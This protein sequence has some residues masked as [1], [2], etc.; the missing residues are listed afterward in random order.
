MRGRQRIEAALSKDGSPEIPAVLCYEGIYV[1]DHWSQL[2]DVPWWHRHSP[3][4]DVQLAWRRQVSDKTGQDWFVLPSFY[5]QEERQRL[6]LRV[7]DDRVW[8]VDTRSGRR[9]ELVRPQV[10]GWSRAIGVQSV[11]PR[12]LAETREAIERLIPIPAPAGQTGEGRGDLAAEML[13]EWGR[14]LYPIC[15]VPSP[16]W[17]CYGLWGFEG[18]MTL[19]AQRPDLVRHAC[20][21]FLRASIG[22]VHRAAQLGA[23]G[24]WIEDCM[25]DLI[26]PDAFWTL[27]VP[28]LSALI[29]EVRACGLHSIYYYCGNPAGKWDALLSVGADA[30]A[31]EESKKGFVIDIED[32][33]RRACGQC[34]VLGNLD[35]IGLLESGTEGELRTE[36]ERQ[37]AAGRQNGSRFVASL[38]SP[39]TPNTPVQRVRRFCD[40]AHEIGSAHL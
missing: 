36:V 23:A 9:T 1:R 24:M 34:A 37:I 22:S 7:E 4:I 12:E 20:E 15:H 14:D 16:L 30:L 40:L 8:L 18:M 38:G 3:S 31:L 33:V 21:R 35:A 2:T 6:D 13:R 29:K 32:V 26:G 28:S 39:V 10:G 5:A 27:N 17:S 19:I 25:T 11:H